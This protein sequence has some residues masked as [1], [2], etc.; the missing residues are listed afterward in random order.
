MKYLVCMGSGIGD[1]ILTLPFLKTIRDND[2]TAYITLFRCGTRKQLNEKKELY[3]F[4]ELADEVVSYAQSEMLYSLGVFL[5]LM[6]KGYDYGFVHQYTDS[7]DTS[8]W[9]AFIVRYACKK[10][11]GTIV[12]QNPRISFN[13]E[14]PR[15]ERDSVTI[16]QL[17]LLE[18]IGY[19]S[20][21]KY[22]GLLPDNKLEIVYRKLH[23]D[24]KISQRKC[25]GLC[26][27]TVP[28]VTRVR[29]KVVEKKIKNWPYEKWSKLADRLT[30][31]GFLVVLFGSPT[32]RDEIGQL[33]CF[34]QFTG[35]NLCGTMSI[36]QT[37]SVLKKMEIIVGADT[38]LM[39]CAAALKRK[40][41]TL[42]GATD[43]KQYL[44]Y[45]NKSYYIAAQ[46]ECAPCFGTAKAG[47]CERNECMNSITVEKVYLKILEILGN[48]DY[49]R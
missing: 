27:G 17:K 5:K 3:K 4:Q 24:E 21:K 31:D 14:V 48:E 46:K 32:E 44:P 10:T 18:E 19:V 28:V 23:I 22:E 37:M 26:V 7:P 45:G 33:D 6:K 49:T 13:I 25:I 30:T 9:P 35:M 43:Y 2:G 38:G 42:F 39:H 11:I 29:G 20:E 8:A 40:S 36:V 16:S 34:Q 1:V 12:P 47:V 15:T 41:L